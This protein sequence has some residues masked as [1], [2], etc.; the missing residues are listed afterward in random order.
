MV[1][2]FY[3]KLL[4]LTQF[5]DSIIFK[6]DPRGVRPIEAPIEYGLGM[7]EV[8]SIK[9][10]D[11]QE[12]YIWIHSSKNNEKS[13]MFIFFHGNAGHLGDTYRTRL[14]QE[15]LKSGHGFIAVSHR[16][17]GNSSGEPSEE[18]FSKDLDAVVNYIENEKSE[19]L[20]IIGESLGASSAL[21]LN[22]KLQRRNIDSEAVVLIAPFTS[23]LGKVEDLHPEIMR[24]DVDSRLDHKFDNMK[25]IKQT[26]YQGKIILLHPEN[27]E[28]TPKRHSKMLYEAAKNRNLNIVYHELKG[29]GHVTWNAQKV[30]EY[31]DAELD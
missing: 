23:I 6:P 24:F 7:T 2:F 4:F 29:A 22:E 1:I 20:V 5:Q 16:G 26:E 8:D 28:T 12:I 9:T 31:I 17:F 11:D 14:L 18:G 10:S 25:I 19:R 13:L 21:A 15:M 3:I 27:D 30:I